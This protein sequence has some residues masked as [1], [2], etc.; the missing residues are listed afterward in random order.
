M[1]KKPINKHPYTM[2]TSTAVMTTQQVADR[3]V[4]LC[5]EGRFLEAGKELYA[6]NIVSL[7]PKGASASERLEG[8]DHVLGKSIEFENMVEQ[9]HGVKVSDAVV[10]ADHFAVALE[11][12]RTF[13]GMGRM[14]M[15]EVAAYKVANGKIVW[16][17]V[18][19]SPPPQN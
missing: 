5:R 3:L 2:S 6:P 7:E 11:V 16:E 17:Q 1:D 19:Y 10:A 9:H 15:A 8:F 12:D 18:C 13:K 14:T 4:A